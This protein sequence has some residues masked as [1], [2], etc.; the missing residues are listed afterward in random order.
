MCGEKVETDK[1]GSGLQGPK[2]QLA[3]V[4]KRYLGDYLRAHR[5]SRLQRRVVEAI[6]ACRTRALGAHLLKCRHCGYEHPAYNPC[7][8]RHCPRCQI[9]AR[10]KWVRQRLSELLPIPYYHCIFTMPHCLNRLA[11]YNKAVIYEMFFQSAIYTLNSFAQDPVHLG[12]Q[13]GF[14]GI[15]HTWG[16]RLNYHVHLHF[17]VTGGGISTDG[18]RWVKLPYT[19]K[20]IF[21]VKAMSQVMRQRFARLLEAAYDCGKLQ[22]PE[23]VAHLAE[24]QA[25]EEFVNKVAWKNWVIFAKPPFAGPDEVVRYIGR[26]THQVAISNYRLLNLDDGKVTFRYKHYKDNTV[27][28]KEMALEAEKFIGRFLMHVI[29]GGFKRI[30]HGGFLA[31]GCR[32]RML[33]LAHKLLSEMAANVEEAKSNF[34]AWLDKLNFLRCPKCQCGALYQVDYIPRE[35]LAPG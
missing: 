27:T 7:G 21:P 3:Q 10:L 16:Q 8:N 29:P 33:A 11:L 2:Y 35:Q 14:V 22:F 4:F 30:R 20:F 24:A 25:F 6:M 1:T 18:K 9:G 32:T 31:A 5:L 26:Y 19:R 23:P 34:E 15:L 12:A 28:I 13:L 17:M